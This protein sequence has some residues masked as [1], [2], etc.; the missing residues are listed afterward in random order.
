MAH[1]APYKMKPTASPLCFLI[2]QRRVWRHQ[3][4]E[5]WDV[6]STRRR[7]LRLRRQG[8]VWTGIQ[9]GSTPPPG[10]SHHKAN[11]HKYRP[12]VSD[13]VNHVYSFSISTKFS[14]R[15]LTNFAVNPILSFTTNNARSRFD[16]DERDCYFEDEI[17]LKHWPYFMG[18]DGQD[19]TNRGEEGRYGT[20]VIAD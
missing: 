2:G 20:P 5:Q 16:P 9:G 14:S 13:C 15:S 17:E 8:Q 12:G 1:T 7:D 4:R 6:P 3:R 10:P 19:V 18:E 11:E